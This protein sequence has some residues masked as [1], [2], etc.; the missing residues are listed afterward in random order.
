M[1]LY[2]LHTVDHHLMGCDRF[3]DLP[4]T[5]RIDRKLHRKQ[6][7]GIFP[8]TLPVEEIS[9][10]A[11]DLS[12]DQ[13]QSRRITHQG[14]LQF[15]LFANANCRNHRCDHSTVDRQASLTQIKYLQQ[16]V[17]VPVPGERNIIDTRTNQRT[18]NSD[19]RQIKIV[20]LILPTAL[21]L[22]QSDKQSHQH[23]KCQRQ[24]IKSDLKIADMD[25]FANMTQINV[26]I[27]EIDIHI[28]KLLELVYQV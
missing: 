11:D 23:C 17:L 9:P 1:H 6:I 7:I 24:S 10:T 12:G 26:K 3:S 8:K 16:I 28:H 4:L 21:C 20:V 2:V 14:E 22:T 27:W 18:D 15:S 19:D 25:R 13:S 5:H